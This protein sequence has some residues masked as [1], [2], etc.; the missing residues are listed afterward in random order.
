MSQNKKNKVITYDIVLKN[1]TLFEN[2]SNIEIKTLDINKENA[3]IIN[4]SNFI[5]LDIDPHD[6]VQEL[7][8]YKNLINIDYKGIVMLDDIHLN[9]GM[10]KFWNNIYHEKY[11][12][13]DIGHWSGTGLINFSKEK[14]III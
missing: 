4:S 13:T 6:G 9:D 8:F 5:L 3:E 14:I 2:Y 10:Q 11:D 12:L 7:N 1:N